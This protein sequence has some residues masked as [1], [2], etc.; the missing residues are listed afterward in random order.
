MSPPFEIP[1]SIPPARLEER[2][3]SL[4][5]CIV[6]Y[7]VLHFRAIASGVFDPRADFNRLDC[8]NGHH[9][10]R[11]FRVELFVPLRVASQARWGSA[12]DNFKDSANRIA[13]FQH[14]IYF[15]F[16]ARFGGRIH[17]AEGRIQIFARRGDFL[18][19]SFAFQA[20]VTYRNRVA[21]N[22]R[23]KLAQKQFRKRAGSHARS[24][25]AR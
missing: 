22:Y 7:F 8:L 21:Q 16:H 17:T 10:A 9:G 3:E 2:A 23:A 15:R 1:P 20:N 13:F 24:C 18:P 19:A 5:A 12:R 11:Q 4:A 25:L 6:A 14:A